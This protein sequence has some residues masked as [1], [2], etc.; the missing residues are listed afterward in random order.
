MLAYRQQLRDIPTKFD[1]L[2]DPDGTATAPE[3]SNYHYDALDWPTK[4]SQ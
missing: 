3:I 1:A 4:P 2:I